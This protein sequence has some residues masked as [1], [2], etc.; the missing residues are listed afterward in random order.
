MK[1]ISS[2]LALAIGLAFTINLLAWPVDQPLMKAARTKLNLA[3]GN[4]NSATPD[5]GGHRN[6][7]LVLVKG[8]LD[9]VEKGI[10][11]D[12]RNSRE[13]F[14]TDEIFPNTEPVSADQP[15]MK[16]AKENLEKGLDDLQKAT[17]DKGGHRNKA[18]D[19]VKEAIN[20]VEKGINFD[21]RN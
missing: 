5:K 4:L 3:K 11:F 7:A 21:R 8:A 17:A 2:L 1:K 14:E 9:E 12:R 10:R 18:I 19:L 13:D 16:K 6:K 15:F 20:E